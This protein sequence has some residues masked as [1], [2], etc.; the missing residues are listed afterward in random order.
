MA[1]LIMTIDSDQEDDKQ[2][3]VKDGDIIM[4][5]NQDAAP[6]VFDD[7]NSDG[8]SDAGYLK[9]E[10]GTKGN[11]WNFGNQL[12]TEKEPTKITADATSN[13]DEDQEM[14]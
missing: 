3:E 7:S 6:M 13:E 5:T 12:K 2:K 11:A 8:S 10:D 4:E 14:A 9:N 1:S